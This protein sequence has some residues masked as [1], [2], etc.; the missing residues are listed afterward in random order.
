MRDVFRRRLLIV[1]ALALS[2]LVVAVPAA[3]MAK[4]RGGHRQSHTATRGRGKSGA[5]HGRGAKFAEVG[6]VYVMSNE[7][8]NA[9]E[10]FG[11]DARGRLSFDGSVLTG[12]MGTGAGLGSQGAL[13]LSADGKWLVAVNAGS[14]DFTVFAVRRGGGLKWVA[15]ASSQG[16]MPVSV[17][18][19]DSWVYVLN[20]GGSG[21]IAGFRLDRHGVPTFLAG[22]SQPLSNL[23]VG[24][25]PV[26]EQIGFKP[27]GGVVVVT[28]K[29]TNMIDVYGL[30]SGIAGP[31]TVFTS[32]GAAPY[33]FAFS[34]SGVLIVSEAAIGALSSYAV[35]PTSLSV[36]SGS[37]P[38]FQLAPCWVA[39]APDGRFAYTSDAHSNDISIFGL[40]PDGTLWLRKSAAVTVS[41]P[42]DLGMPHNGRFLFVLAAGSHTVDGFGIRAHGALKGLGS[43]GV[44]PAS[45]SGLVTW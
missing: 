8:S 23:G 7:T 26:A 42:L 15:Q 12:G 9:I 37:V 22:S 36:I 29:S 17:T 28:E 11:R 31:P 39:V 24:A 44:L 21:N 18:M 41:T 5:S 14:N 13:A 1:L 19:R 16:T 6:T 20:D 4:G 25:A 2:V 30:A 32:N 45:A 35:L 3:A 27:Y 43:F 34:H 38:D 40:R 33:G 10:V